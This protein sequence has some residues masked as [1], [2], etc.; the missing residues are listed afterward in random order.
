MPR[1]QPARHLCLQETRPLVHYHQG[2]AGYK[3]QACCEKAAEGLRW[4]KRLAVRRSPLFGGYFNR[5]P[6]RI[7][8][9]TGV[10]PSRC[11]VSAVS[12]LRYFR[13]WLFSAARVRAPSRL[14]CSLAQILTSPDVVIS[15]CSQL[16][17]RLV[18]RRIAGSAGRSLRRQRP[19]RPSLRRL[20]YPE[21]VDPIPD[22]AAR[23]DSG[24]GGG[25][26]RLFRRWP[27][28]LPSCRPLGRR[29]ALRATRR[30]AGRQRFLLGYQ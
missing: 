12:I 26:R 23:A 14:L 25:G 28:G 15:Y 7:A 16:R 27:R 24:E 30:G 5:D 29:P 11:E 4:H 9:A 21:R 22:H 6:H 17:R 1:R 3:P 2:V 10:S 8:H 13:L 19:A 20:A 18:F